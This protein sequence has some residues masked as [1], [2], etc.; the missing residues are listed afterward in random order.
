MSAITD[1]SLISWGDSLVVENNYGYENITSLTFGRS[2]V[3]GVTRIDVREDGSGCDTVWESAVRAPRRPC[4][5]SPPRR[6]LYFYD[7]GAQQR[8]A[9]TPG[10]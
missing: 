9:S 8:P 5:N 6:L 1:N 2:V 4:R 3:G 7:E 10:T